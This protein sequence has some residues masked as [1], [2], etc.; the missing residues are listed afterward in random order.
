MKPRGPDGKNT[1]TFRFQSEL[2]D[3][4]RGA[5]PP[6]A[7]PPHSRLVDNK[8][9]SFKPITTHF[10]RLVAAGD[11]ANSCSQD[12]TGRVSLPVFV[13]SVS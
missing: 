2:W 5:P 9:H 10:V 7:P 13:S 1:A 3:S 6:P 11:E 4:Q 12:V 8:G